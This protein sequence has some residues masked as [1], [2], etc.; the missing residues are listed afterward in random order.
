M[1]RKVLFLRCRSGFGR[2]GVARPRRQWR[3][4]IGV[5]L[6]DGVAGPVPL[7]PAPIAVFDDQ[8]GKGVTRASDSPLV[9][10]F[11]SLFSSFSV[12]RYKHC[13]HN[14][15]L[16]RGLFCPYELALRADSTVAA[17]GFDGNG[18]VSGALGLTN[19]GAVA[20]SGTH[21]LAL[22]KDGTVT[23][24]GTNS[25]GQTNVPDGLSNVVAIACGY[26]HSLALK[27]DGT[28][29]AWGLNASGETSIPAGLRRVVGIAA[30]QDS[31]CALVCDL[32]IDSIRFN[33]SNPE[34]RFRTFVDEYYTVE[35]SPDL[36]P[37]S[38]TALPG[39][40]ITGIGTEAMFRD[41]STTDRPRFYRVR[42][43]P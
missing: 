1:G 9:R 17:W 28:V 42:L 21:A 7:G 5:G 24:W 29:V 3:V 32:R 22:L 16:S 15:K 34:L 31:S 8:P 12:I 25:F 26:A 40:S 43:K 11:S 13:F 2:T 14:G 10:Q 39:G 4:C 36:A 18:A 6:L 23:A 33:G 35:S 37:G 41:T 20:A 27:S 19:V 38:W 30:G